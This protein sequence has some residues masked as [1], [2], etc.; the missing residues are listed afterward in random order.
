MVILYIYSTLTCISL[1][2]C[3]LV[4]EIFSYYF[5]DPYR[6]SIGLNWE[7]S[8]LIQFTYVLILYCCVCWAVRYH[9]DEDP[10]CINVIKIPLLDSKGLPVHYDRLAVSPDNQSLAV[11]HGSTVQW[12]RFETGEVLDTAE[13]AHDGACRLLIIILLVH[14]SIREGL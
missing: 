13:N 5:S 12:L 9:M 3:V 7:C 2:F 14:S 1:E 4:C 11:T 6:F 8:C 10:K